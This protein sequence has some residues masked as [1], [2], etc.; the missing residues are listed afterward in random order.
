[1]TIDRRAFLTG[2]AAAS[3]AAITPAIDTGDGVSL[4]SAAHPPAEKGFGLAPLKE[5]GKPVAYDQQHHQRWVSH[6]RLESEHWQAMDYT[7]VA[8]HPQ[9]DISLVDYFT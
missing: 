4:Y 7:V 2:L 6:E 5:E 9:L 8:V 1:M 3:A